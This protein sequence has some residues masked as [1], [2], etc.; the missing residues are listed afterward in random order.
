[1]S[2]TTKQ[3]RE[4]ARV[5]VT[6]LSYHRREFGK[7]SLEFLDWLLDDADRLARLEQQVREL[8]DWWGL[9]AEEAEQNVPGGDLQTGMLRLHEAKLRAL[10]DPPT[11]R[12]PEEADDLDEW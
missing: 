3:K 11:I 2:E 10:L 1:M 7:I 9:I 6:M 5:G 12:D 8:A 4:N